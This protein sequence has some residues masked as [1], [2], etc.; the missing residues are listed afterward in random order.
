MV[1]QLSQNVK[2]SLSEHVTLVSIAKGIIVSYLITLP[3]FMIFAFVLTYTDFPEK[4]IPAC[5]IIV[6]VMSV[7]VAG[8]T[9]TRNVRNKGWINGAFVGFVYMLILYVFSSITFNDFS[10]DKD[11]AMKA[12]IGVI[13]G[14]IGGIIGINLK[15]RQSRGRNR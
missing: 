5:V 1:R 4:Y 9:A 2:A 6:T 3:A 11:V 12:A 14:S 7:L 8:S 15:R 13:T 10:I